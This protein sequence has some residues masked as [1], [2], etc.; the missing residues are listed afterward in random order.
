MKLKPFPA[1]YPNFDFIA[2]PD[3][4]C[5]DAK[6]SFR[7]FLD[8]GFFEKMPNDALY[9][10]QIESRKR[11]HTG[12]IGLNEVEDFFAGKV[13]KHEKTLSEREHQQM[14]LFMQWNA[15]LKPVLLTYPT[16]PAINA[17]L[18][19][20]LQAHPP[21][22]S[23]RFVRDEETHRV[24]TVT[25]PSDIRLLQELF[26]ANIHGVYIADGHHRTST[27]AL[28]HERLK[29]KSPEYD[30]DHLFCAFFSV[31][32]LDILDYNRVVSG[33]K[34]INPMQFA[35]KLTQHFTISPLEEARKPACKHEIILLIK[36]EWY[37]LQVKPEVL[38]K[39]G[40][41]TVV[42]DANL[43][44]ELVLRDIFGIAD[45]RTDTRITYIEGSKGLEGIKKSV[46]K[47]ADRVGFML[48]PVDI[49]DMMGLA[50]INE[51]LP[52]KS[53]YFEPRMKSGMLVKLL[54]S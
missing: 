46:G 43:L 53:T 47:S 22:F 11:K 16:V 8:H 18:E 41:D 44:N 19:N 27:V 33:L 50:D 5:N 35:I 42:L 52:P 2:S 37:S 48:Y 26:S 21:L 28:L 49:D 30:F 17:W 15:I 7:S 38:E 25:N 6:E 45:I 1:L 24:W 3:A 32:Q 10:Y 9:I 36:K 31:D 23:T 14:Q 54:K 29:D 4:F 51:S 12:L 40:P 34:N 13:K 39:Y 20:Y